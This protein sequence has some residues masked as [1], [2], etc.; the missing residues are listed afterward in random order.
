MSNSFLAVGEYLLNPELVAYATVDNDRADPGLRLLFT[1]SSP[2]AGGELLLAGEE[3]RE[4][5]RWLR[6]NA[7]YLTKGGGFGLIGRS[8][9]PAVDREPRNNPGNLAA[10]ASP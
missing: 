6:L 5:L 1:A 3:A 7:T 10:L 4:V 8:T 9:E 2:D